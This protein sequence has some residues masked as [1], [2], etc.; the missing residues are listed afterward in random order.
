MSMLRA[1]HNGERPASDAAKN[2]A[3]LVLD[4]KPVD[5]ED[6]TEV[7]EQE[8][9]DMPRKYNKQEINKAVIDCD[10]LLDYNE[11]EILLWDKT[12]NA[13]PTQLSNT[14]YQY[15]SYVHSGWWTEDRKFITVHDEL[16][17]QRYGLQ[18]R[19][20]FFSL[21]NLRNLELAGEYVGPTAAIDHNGYVRGNRYYFSNYERGLVVL[22]ISDP[23]NPKEAGFFDTYP[24]SNWA[25]LIGAFGVLS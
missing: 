15:V 10:V 5:E 6:L 20:R 22:D 3:Q 24:I 1:I 25:S 11:N 16:D 9:F 4:A 21:D 12:N 8:K 2:F 7:V 18:T 19:V 17:E 14:L 23:R 13:T